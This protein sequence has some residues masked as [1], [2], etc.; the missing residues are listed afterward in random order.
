MGRKTSSKLSS[1]PSVS[2]PS[3][4]RSIHLWLLSKLVLMTVMMMMMM[5]MVMTTTTTVV[6]AEQKQKT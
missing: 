5:M 4:H 1:I 6:R 3:V 2:H